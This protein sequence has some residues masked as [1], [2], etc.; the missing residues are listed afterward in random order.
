MVRVPTLLAERL[1][2]WRVS[3]SDEGGSSEEVAGVTEVPGQG[4]E[5]GRLGSPAVGVG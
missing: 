3:F 2:R 5:R 1:G 4:R